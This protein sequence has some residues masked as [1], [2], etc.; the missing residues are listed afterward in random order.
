MQDRSR[1]GSV[2]GSQ[3]GSSRAVGKR[4]TNVIQ[5]RGQMYDV[6]RPM[7]NKSMPFSYAF[8]RDA[9]VGWSCTR[10]WGCTRG[11]MQKARDGHGDRPGPLLARWHVIPPPPVHDRPAAP[12]WSG[13]PLPPR[14]AR[15]S[16]RSRPHPRVRR[17]ARLAGWRAVYRPVGPL[18][19]ARASAGMYTLQ[20]VGPRRK[21]SRQPDLHL[22]TAEMPRYSPRPAI[23]G[24]APEPAQAPDDSRPAPLSPRRT[25]DR[26]P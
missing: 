24:F 5:F 14:L 22:T 25:A 7:Y 23:T 13:I 20:W 11:G 3:G 21:G 9:R 2:L 17:S 8:A 16:A 19:A 12:G 10:R 18:V 4:S 1:F 6:R 26:S 15:R